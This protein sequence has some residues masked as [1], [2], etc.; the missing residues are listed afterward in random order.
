MISL[1]HISLQR[2]SKPL[3]HDVDITL[4]SG[5]RIGLTGANGTGILAAVTGVDGNHHMRDAFG[6]WVAIEDARDP[7]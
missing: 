3:F 1:K 6:A 7:R 2:G 5:Q 4:H